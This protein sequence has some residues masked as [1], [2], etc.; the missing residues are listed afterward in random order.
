MERW[1]QKS[2]AVRYIRREKRLGV[3]ETLLLLLEQSRGEYVWFFG[4]DDVLKAGAVEQVRQRILAS[5]DRPTL[6]YLNHEIV[7]MNRRTLIRSQVRQQA[8]RRFREGARAVPWLGMNLGYISACVLRRA[9][10]VQVR[11]ATGF[12]G[13]RWVSMHLYL[14]S[15]LSGG[16]LEY[17]GRPQLESRRNPSACSEYAEVFVRQANRVLA[18][19]RRRGYSWY[20]MLRTR[21]RICRDHYLRFVFSWRC[22]DPRELERTFPEIFRAFW[23]CPSFWLLLVPVRFAPAAIARAARGYL[24]QRRTQLNQKRAMQIDPC[25]QARPEMLPPRNRLRA[26]LRVL[27]AARKLSD[28]ADADAVLRAIPFAVPAF[29]K[30]YVRFR[31]LETIQTEFRRHTVFLNPQDLEITRRMLTLASWEPFETEVFE[32]VLRPGMTL[33]DVGANIGHYTLEAA[34]RVGAAGRVIAFEPE[35]NNFEL[36]CRNIEANRY[37]NVTPVR[38]ALSNHSGVARLALS[39]E[40]LGG[41]HLEYA[42]GDSR[43]IAI[44]ML[45]LDEY[46][47]GTAQ[48]VDVLKMD[49]EGSEL[50]ILEGM[51]ELLHFNPNLILFTEFCPAALE[52]AGCSPLRFLE[53]L[54]S[55]GFQIGIIG[56]KKNR[57]ENLSAGSWEEFVTSLLRS[58]HGRFYVNLLC[59]RGQALQSAYGPANWRPGAAVAVA[60]QR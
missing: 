44:E 31:P 56:A 38:K 11:S 33:V 4:S 54:A 19:A 10:A 39:A 50:F 55:H 42:S 40:N 21:D 8:D 6:I 59:L 47:R 46:F 15:L 12:V 30:L 52:A 45:T 7:D 16:A 34:R 3:D 17:I 14:I 36:L 28:R 32:Q 41:H 1:E 49:A 5:V 53:K 29:R 51:S 37:A 18:D 27:L 9:K 13:S 25:A 20:A 60:G 22:E 26:P 57:I 48:A 43:S 2:S 58:D 35:P 24:L 23:M